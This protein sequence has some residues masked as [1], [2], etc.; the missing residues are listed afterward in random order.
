[1]AAGLA[2]YLNSSMVDRYFRQF[3]G[4]TQV[5]AADLRALRYPALDALER[6]GR[7]IEQAEI[8]QEQIDDI[9]GEELADVMEY[10]PL[11][12]A[13]QKI[14]D[15]LVVLRAIEMPQGQLNERSAL[16]LLALLDLKPAGNWND[17]RRPLMGI[18]PIIGFARQE[19]G[20]EYAPNTRETF[21]RQ[22][23]HQFVQAGVA[24]YNPDDPNRPVNS[25][26]ASYQVS[27]ETFRFSRHT[28]PIAGS[29]RLMT[30]WKK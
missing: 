24:L 21:R 27:E 10:D 17:L 29:K 12:L 2:A 5:N 1:M 18:T 30:T 28:V 25:P 16:T 7:R 13:Q 6:I 22:T 19:Y 11:A 9:V 8:S 26:L 23:M 3:S 4:H 20:R 15:A 14:N